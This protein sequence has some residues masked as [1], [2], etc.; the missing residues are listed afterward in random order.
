MLVTS[1]ALNP[2]G[3]GNLCEC[4]TYY[5]QLRRNLEIF[6]CSKSD[7]TLFSLLVLTAAVTQA[8]L[9]SMLHKLLTA[10]PSAFN[11]TSILSQ[12]A[13]LSNQGGFLTIGAL[14]YFPMILIVQSQIVFS[15]IPSNSPTIQPVTHVINVRCFIAQVICF[16]P[17]QHTTDQCWSPETSPQHTVCHL[18]VKSKDLFKM[19][20][21]E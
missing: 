16:P 5:I 20:L 3:M 17:D 14:M 13:Q 18:A 6:S 8:S 15:N 12:A 2:S 7:Y 19:Y 1:V 21:V 11:L 9:Q 4:R 10:G